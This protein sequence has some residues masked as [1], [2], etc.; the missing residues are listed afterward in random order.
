[1]AGS[2]NKSSCFAP[3]KF[4]IVID[5]ILVTLWSHFVVLFKSDLDVQQTHLWKIWAKQKI[6]LMNETKWY[7]ILPRQK[8]WVQE[9]FQTVSQNFAKCLNESWHK[10]HQFCMDKSEQNEVQGPVS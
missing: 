1:M 4:I 5:M 6:L 2:L 7:K 8:S 9:I 10:F 3:E